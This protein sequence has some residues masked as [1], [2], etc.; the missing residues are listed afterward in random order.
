MFSPTPAK[1]LAVPPSSRQNSPTAPWSRAPEASLAVVPAL[2]GGWR[3][4]AGDRRPALAQGG[5]AGSCPHEEL[6][7][8]VGVR[9]FRA[10]GVLLPRGPSARLWATA[11]DSGDLVEA[12]LAMRTLKMS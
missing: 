8:G 3:M 5:I 2:V 6:N 10:P 1:G 11:G 7:V 4:L 12:T 9:P